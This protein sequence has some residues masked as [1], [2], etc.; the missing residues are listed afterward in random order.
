[1]ACSKI[2]GKYDDCSG[3]ESNSDNHPM[4]NISL[5]MLNGYWEP[6]T[7][8]DWNQHSCACHLMYFE[9]GLCVPHQHLN[10]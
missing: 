6:K 5:T 9:V 7:H 2:K 10:K 1:M 3:L 8:I 4:P